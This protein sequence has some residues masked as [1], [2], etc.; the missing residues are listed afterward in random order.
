MAKAVAQK[1]CTTRLLACGAPAPAHPAPTR[2]MAP[3]AHVIHVYRAA[4]GSESAEYMPRPGANGCLRDARCPPRRHH[5]PA[6]RRKKLSATQRERRTPYHM[7]PISIFV[8]ECTL[9]PRAVSLTHIATA[10]PHARAVSLTH[11]PT[12]IPKQTSTTYPAYPADPTRDSAY[13][14]SSSHPPRS[15]AA[16]F[17]LSSPPPP[18]CLSCSVSLL[19]NGQHTAPA[20]AQCLLGTSEPVPAATL[21]P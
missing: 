15:P 14:L 13:P 21:A 19:A 17:A 2:A 11:T 20:P 10:I 16:T 18:L 5:E 7:K 8:H 1:M 9:M 12:A 3:H 4:S 6:A